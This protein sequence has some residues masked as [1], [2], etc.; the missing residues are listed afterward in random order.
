[1]RAPSTISMPD[2]PAAGLAASLRAACELIT[3]PS[4]VARTASMTFVVDREDGAAIA[5]LR[6]ADGLTAEFGLCQ[7]VELNGRIATIHL[8]RSEES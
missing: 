8:W 7:R 5:V 1:M 3:D 6:Q 4:G 2:D